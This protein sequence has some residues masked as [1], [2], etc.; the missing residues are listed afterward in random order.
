MPRV[1]KDEK[2]STTSNTKKIDSKSKKVASSTTKKPATKSKADT[3]KKATKVKATTSKKTDTAKETTSKKTT[4]V[5]ASTSKKTTKATTKA[6]KTSSKVSKTEKKTTTK[7]STASK[8]KSTSKKVVSKTNSPSIME[9][10]DLP[11]RYNETTVRILA[12]TPKKLFIYWD[13][14]DDD[15]KNYI[16]T[17]GENFFNNT[18]PVLIIHNTT[19]N[20]SFE[21][22]INDFAN[23]WYLNINDAKSEYTIELGRRFRNPNNENVPQYLYITSSNKIESPNDHIL[24]EKQQ[25]M[26]YFRNVKNNTIYSKDI[27]SLTLLKNMGKIYDIYDVYKKIY[28]DEDIY[29]I[30]NPSSNNPSSRV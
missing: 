24:F 21:V 29:D 28:K 2:V 11:Y 22:E 19:L 18:I 3:S 5:S 8:A 14:S 12:Q 15:R 30:N 27:S 25:K 7:K 1:T 6:T 9:Y 23:C 13:I 20:Y 17:F 4:K 10:Y 16:N 26:V